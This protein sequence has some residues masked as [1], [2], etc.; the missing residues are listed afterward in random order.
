MLFLLL[1]MMLM[2]LMMLGEKGSMERVSVPHLYISCSLPELGATNKRTDDY[3]RPAFPHPILV[4]A[5]E[6]PGGPEG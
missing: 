2:M 4:K 5:S 1:M 3:A 6:S